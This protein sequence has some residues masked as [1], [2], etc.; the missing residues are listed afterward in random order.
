MT[1]P[2]FLALLFFQAPA[3]QPKPATLE[4][5]V[6][7]AATQTP[8]RKAK[9]SLSAIGFE[10]GGSAETADDG[11]FTFKDVKPG[12]YR[13]TAEKA[14][15]ETTPYGV[16]RPGEGGG[17]VL[18]VDSGASFNTLNIALP[19]QGVIAGKILDSDSEP[20]AKALVMA[21]GKTYAQGK[22]IWL[23][24]GSVPVMSNDLGEFRI[25][26]LPP[27]KFIVCAIPF[28]WVNPALPDSATKPATEE[29]AATTCF[30]NVPHLTEATALE[31]KDSTEVPGIDIRLN[32]TRTV[33]VQ[34]HV[35]GL[36]SSGAG[37]V[38]IL[39]LNSKAD[40]PIG[41]ALH[42]RA[43]VASA[44]G[45]FEFRNVPPGSYIIHS[46]PTGLGNAPYVVKATVEIGDQPITSLDV[47]AFVPFELKAKITAEPDPD[48][49]LPSIRAILTSADGINASVA[50][51]SANP[52]GD[53]TISNAV[54]GRHRIYFQGVPPTHY[55]AQLRLGDQ[56][57]SADEVEISS[58][59]APLSIQIARS[60]NEV[61]GLVRD[62]KGDPTPGAAVA[63]VSDPRRPYRMK[64]ARTDQNGVFKIGGVA[65]GD[66]LAISIEPLLDG[67]NAL[68]D[69][70][71]LKP[72]LSK[73][74]KVKVQD[75]SSPSVE[76][77]VL[78]AP[79][80]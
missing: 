73:M 42:P 75:G 69:E 3:E 14:G 80:R 40:G 63:L 58:A 62:E 72:L 56:I 67:G 77:T 32:K 78:P 6:T 66:Y 37:S 54:P 22:Q 21:L 2:L 29:A 28:N 64:F 41:N 68:E 38:T 35:T 4:G 79:E 33:S 48:L 26:Q 46:L 44:D 23:P 65:P 17:Q 52:D 13:I 24:R 16:R 36:P 8:I 9:V 71:Y 15:Y 60:K 12:R 47:P 1:A 39:N 25:G 53:I 49:K 45:K 59:A 11:K 70:D 10:G 74:K 18:R 27:G 20:V 76:L 61:S 51:G 31:I 57:L 5:V 50:M 55:I 7:H 30:P 43:I 19:K 34:G